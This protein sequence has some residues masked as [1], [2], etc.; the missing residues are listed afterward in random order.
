MTYLLVFGVKDRDLMRLLHEL[1]LLALQDVRRRHRPALVGRVGGCSARKFDFAVSP[2]G[3]GRIRLQDRV[4]VIADKRVEI[5]LS[6]DARAI[7]H[8]P[9]TRNWR[10]KPNIGPGPNAGEIGNWQGR[11]G[12]HR[13]DE[14]HRT[15][16]AECNRVSGL[17]VLTPRSI[18][19]NFSLATREVKMG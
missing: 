4:G 2:D 12:Q 19:R 1:Y 14:D 9:G 10:F 5:T 15:G 11:R 8:G 6:V 16:A 18:H 7:E 17:H 13:R 3:I